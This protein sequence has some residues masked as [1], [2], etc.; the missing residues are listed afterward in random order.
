MIYKEVSDRRE[1]I[2]RRD[3]TRR[4]NMFY[5]I[6]LQVSI[7]QCFEAI[8]SSRLLLGYGCYTIDDRFADLFLQ[9]EFHCN[10][11]PDLRESLSTA[12]YRHSRERKY[13]TGKIDS[14]LHRRRELSSAVGNSK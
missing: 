12:V 10:Y 6:P 14:L 2:D 1:A 7:S 9:T 13:P 4:N 5:F 11:S 3:G 8:E